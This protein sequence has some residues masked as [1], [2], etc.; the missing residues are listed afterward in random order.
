MEAREISQLRYP[1]IG[2][3]LLPAHWPELKPRLSYEARIGSAFESRFSL[4]LPE[5]RPPHRMDHWMRSMDRLLK[6]VLSRFIR[7]GTLAVTPT[8]GRT[9]TCGDGTGEPVAV[10]FL[11]RAAERRLL[12]DPELRSEEHRALRYA[13]AGRGGSVMGEAP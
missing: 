13:I 12:L 10:R 7:K 6:F 3:A 8:S 4:R 5:H 2:T 9:F 11:T 1:K